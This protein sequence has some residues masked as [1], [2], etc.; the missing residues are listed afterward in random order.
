MKDEKDIEDP[1][2]EAV[3]DKS[4]EEVEEV[5]ENVTKVMEDLIL[6]I[7]NRDLR[8]GVCL[9]V[10]FIAIQEIS[11][12]TDIDRARVEIIKMFKSLDEIRG[13]VS[14]AKRQSKRA[15]YKH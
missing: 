2:Y 6:P 3:G 14:S 5:I 11:T 8:F 1:Q 10:A 7:S 13:E 9:N 4:A 12:L 15:E